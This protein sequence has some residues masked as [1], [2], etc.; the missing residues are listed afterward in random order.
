MPKVQIIMGTVEVDLMVGSS[1]SMYH[2]FIT[3]AH[4][5]DAAIGQANAPEHPSADF[6]LI[7]LAVNKPART[8]SPITDRIAPSPCSLC[9]GM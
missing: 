2:G 4:R 1:H 8:A 3:G 7:P 5:R 9:G 6:L